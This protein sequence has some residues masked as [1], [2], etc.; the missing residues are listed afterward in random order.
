[1]TFRA[2]PKKVHAGHNL[3][4]IG[5][6]LP[7][8]SLL[9]VPSTAAGH[10]I[11][12]TIPPYVPYRTFATFLESL[13]GGVPSRIDSSVLRSMSGGVRG[14]LKAALRSMQL[15]DA[16][17]V[18]TT[19]LHRLV[20]A[21][22]TMRQRLLRELFA[23]TYEFL[24][25]RVDLAAATPA[26]IEAAFA[27]RGA[28]GD[29]V[30]KSIAFMLSM[31]KEAGVGLSP[32]LVKRGAIRRSDGRRRRPGLVEP[33]QASPRAA[34]RS[35]GAPS[36][37]GS[38]TAAPIAELVQKLPPFDATWSDELKLKW[39]AAYDRLMSAILG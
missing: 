32:H 11:P 30:R 33:P 9:V 13:K 22:G 20:A 31:A 23:G 24:G 29:T 27:A 5:Y 26:E 7:A 1:M 4:W 2:R 36:Q 37:A 14:W 39:F 18:P 35:E 10:S 28:R 25:R 17:D 16:S 19:A 8:G 15:I 12:S 21:E 3:V 6:K 38:G 34:L